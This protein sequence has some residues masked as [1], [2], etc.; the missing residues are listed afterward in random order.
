MGFGLAVKCF[1]LVI[2]ESNIDPS[3]ILFMF[4]E[5][6]QNE[7]SA[8]EV[9]ICFPADVDSLSDLLDFYLELLDHKDEIA[10]S[11]SPTD[12]EWNI[13]NSLYYCSSL[14]TTVGK[15]WGH[16]TAEMAI[17]KFGWFQLDCVPNSKHSHTVL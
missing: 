7:Q 12:Q 1:R 8:Q 4:E 9:P 17:L 16:T 14:Y 10:V 6:K 5:N 2:H 3:L 13:I 15:T 11:K